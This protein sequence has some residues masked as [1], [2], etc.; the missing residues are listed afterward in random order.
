MWIVEAVRIARRV[1]IKI[2]NFIKGIGKE[3]TMSR[4]KQ[5]EEMARV[6]CPFPKQHDCNGC[7]KRCYEIS[8]SEM[9]YDAGYRKQSEWISV[10]E[11]LP[12]EGGK[13]VVYRKL[14]TGLS[15]VDI[16]NYDTNY[17]GHA[18]WYF[19]DSDWGDCE[20]NNVTHWMPLPE[21]P[22]MKGGAE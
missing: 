9:L 8:I 11:R 19:V 6:W 21:A 15:S 17:D 7:C 4:E 3:Q 12:D 1:A 22:K 14:Y 5:I 13:Y 20:V 18:M 2:A 16:I 10:D